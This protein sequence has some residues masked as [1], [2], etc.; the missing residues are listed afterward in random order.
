[1]SL[2]RF[3]GIR[4]KHYLIKG[5]AEN[6]KRVYAVAEMAEGEIWVGSDVGLLHLDKA[7]DDLEAVEPVLIDAPVYCLLSDGKQT[8][9]GRH[10]QG[11][12]VYEGRQDA[13]HPD[14]QERVF[15]MERNQRVEHRRRWPFVAGYF[16]RGSGFAY[17]FGQAGDVCIPEPVLL[18]DPYRR[19]IVSGNDERRNRYVRY[20]GKGFRQAGGCGCS[21]ISSLS[22]DGK[23]LLYGVGTDGNGVHFV[24][25]TQRKVVKSFRHETGNDASIRSNSVYSL[26]VDRDGLLWIGFYQ[27]GVDYTLYNN[28]LFAAYQYPP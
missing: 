8:L 19:G 16:E 10:A 17:C 28:G 12:F 9:Y 23:D 22:T 11:L 14:R 27:L 5:K 24:S 13:S 21:V 15:A 6:L 26:L 4:L 18:A 2:E 7:T 20:A 25:V 1:M 3:D